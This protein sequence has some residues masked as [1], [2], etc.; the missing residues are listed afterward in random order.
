M[1]S[2]A[3][4]GTGRSRMSAPISAPKISPHFSQI[5]L[6]RDS[7]HFAPELLSKMEGRPSV[8]VVHN[9]GESAEHRNEPDAF[10]NLGRHSVFCGAEV[11]KS[12]GG[13]SRCRSMVGRMRS[14][15]GL[16]EA[17]NAAAIPLLHHFRR[18]AASGGEELVGV[19]P[20][21]CVVSSLG[22]EPRTH[23][24]KGRCSTN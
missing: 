4:P 3:F 19:T 12:F 6:V 11:E 5:L 13:P 20:L 16:G 17:G 8:F 14:K 9:R 10:V 15:R 1:L 7:A 21:F 2:G 24:L 23:A 22:L 18:L